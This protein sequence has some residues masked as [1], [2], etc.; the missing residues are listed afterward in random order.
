MIA[1]VSSNVEAAFPKDHH[2]RSIREVVSGSQFTVSAVELVITQYGPL[3]EQITLD[4]EVC[5]FE[6]T[7]QTFKLAGSPKPMTS[8]PDIK[9]LHKTVFSSVKKDTQPRTG[10]DGALDSVPSQMSPLS[11]QRVPETQS[12]ASEV[13]DENHEPEAAETQSQFATQPPP[14]RKRKRVSESRIG[15]PDH[16]PVDVQKD[17][18]RA[19]EGK[20]DLLS[21]IS[22]SRPPKRGNIEEIQQGTRETSDDSD[23]EDFAEAIEKQPDREPREQT[24]TDT[25]GEDEK[26]GPRL[27]TQQTTLESVNAEFESSSQQPWHVSITA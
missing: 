18:K 8:H 13:E 4:I 10:Y 22:G 24:T 6:S 16:P 1:R 12:P 27:E 14:S 2:G 15:L 23:D 26:Q 20:T 25:S 11:E 19:R 7:T 5:I 21:L 9:R 17:I 3:E